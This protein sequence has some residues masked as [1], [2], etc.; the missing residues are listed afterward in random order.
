MIEETSS[1]RAPSVDASLIDAAGRLLDDT[2]RLRR[3]IH[4]HPEIGLDLPAT[5][6]A[7][8]EALADLGLDPTAGQNTS[9]VVAAIEGDRPGPTTLLRA[10]MDALE[11]PE[12]TGLDFA[13]TIAGKMHACGH[14]AH[15]AMLVAAARLLTDRRG[16]LAGRVVL[17]FQPGEEGH[18]GAKIMLEEGLLDAHGPVDRAFAIHISPSLP[19][20][21]V[22]CRPG[23][24]LASADEFQLTVTGRGGHASMPHDVIDPVPVACEI[25]TALQAMMTRRVPAFDPA[26]LTITTITAGTTFNVIPERVV[27]TGT[28]RAVSEGSRQLALEGLRRVAEHVAEAHGCRAEVTMIAI[29]I[30]SPSTTR[31]RPS[32]RC[33]WP[34][35]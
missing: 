3:R 12:D 7:V 21:M 13:S 14:D 9:S 30:R 24:M 28:I 26:V 20:G 17:M 18:G 16:D 23:T 8:L 35:T 33:R 1:D 25:V 6:E 27:C 10:D 31:P 22:A 32:G 2:V 4:A 34:L 5:Q 11:M 19:T 29:I 15:V